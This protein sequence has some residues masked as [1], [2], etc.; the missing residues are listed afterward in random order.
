ME[1]LKF[2]ASLWNLVLVHPLSNALTLLYS[3]LWNN[4][5][6]AI[7]VLALLAG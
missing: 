4:F 5:G 6:L 7:I 3:L 2:A 1:L